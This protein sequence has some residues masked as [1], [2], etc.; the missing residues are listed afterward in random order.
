MGNIKRNIRKLIST[1]VAAAMTLTGLSIT[2]VT[3]FGATKALETTGVYTAPTEAIKGAQNMGTIDN[4]AATTYWFGG[5]AFYGMKRN[6]IEFGEDYDTSDW[7]LADTDA[8]W[9]GSYLYSTWG[10]GYNNKDNDTSDLMT[11]SVNADTDVTAKKEKNFYYQKIL[12]YNEALYQQKV[13]SWLKGKEADA[14][15]EA[16]VTTTGG[17]YRTYEDHVQAAS[18]EGDANKYNYYIGAMDVDTNPLTAGFS[19]VID[20]V[21]KWYESGQKDTTKYLPVNDGYP[22]LTGSA[23]ATD[24]TWINK[25]N[26]VV[27]YENRTGTYINS[28]DYNGINEIDLGVK[29]S[30]IYSLKNAH[31]F[32]PSQTEY[33][34]NEKVYKAIINNI[35]NDATSST[36]DDVDVSSSSGLYYASSSIPAG[37]K[38]YP[39]AAKNGKYTWGNAPRNPKGNLYD[40][41]RTDLWSR[42][43]SG[44]RMND[45][46]FGAWSV[47]LHGYL[48]SGDNLT[49]SRAVAPA[50]NLDTSSVT[51]ARSANAAGTAAKSDLDVYDADNLGENVNFEL[52][53]DNLAI[54]TGFNGQEITNL[55]S[56]ETFSIPYTISKL[57]KTATQSADTK[58]YVSAGIYDTSNKLL[59]YG[60]L[61]EVTGTGAGTAELTI[62]TGLSNDKN[63]KLAVFLEQING[64]YN[65]DTPAGNHITT[66]TTDYASPMNVAAF[67][68]DYSGSENPE[69]NGWESVTEDGITWHYTSDG[70]TADHVWTDADDISGLIKN[71]TLYVPSRINGLKVSGIGGGARNKTFVKAGA[72]GV[73]NAIS[74][75][76]SLEKINDLAFVDFDNAFTASIPWTVK[77]IGKKA[78]ENSGIVN[79]VLDGCTGSIEEGAFRNCK[80]LDEV[81]I[82]KG[83]AAL[84]LKAKAFENSDGF[85]TITIPDNASINA[86]TFSGCGIGTVDY[87]GVELPENSFAGCTSITDVFL[88]ENVATVNYNWNGQADVQST[89][90]RR[91]VV[92][93]GDTEFEFY[94]DSTDKY[95]AFGTKGIVTVFYNQGSTTGTKS[96]T[97]NITKVKTTI[98]EKYKD[99]VEYTAYYKDGGTNLA[100]DVIFVSANSISSSDDD[101]EKNAYA[102]LSEGAVAVQDGILAYAT[103]NV[104]FDDTKGGTKLEKNNYAVIAKY[105]DTLGNE[106]DNDKKYAIRSSEIAGKTDDEIKKATVS[107]NAEDLAKGYIDVTAVVFENKDN[108]SEAKFTSPFRV[109]VD[110]YEGKAYVEDKYDNDFEYI[111]GAIEDLEEEVANLEKAAE[112]VQKDIEALTE[113]NEGLSADLL[114]KTNEAKNL[115]ASIEAKQT[116]LDNLTTELEKFT[117]AEGKPTAYTGIK[118]DGTKVVYIGVEGTPYNETDKKVNINGVAYDVFVTTAD[119]KDSAGTVLAPSGTYFYIGSDGVHK[120]TVSGSLV[121][122]GNLATDENG[123]TVYSTEIEDGEGNGKTVYFT[124]DDGGNATIV[125]EKENGNFTEKADQGDAGAAKEKADNNEYKPVTTEE[126]YDDSLAAAVEAAKEQLASIQAS[127]DES[128]ANLTKAASGL[129]SIITALAT[130]GYNIDPDAPDVY[131]QICNAIYDLIKKLKNDGGNNGGN[132][133]GD[134][135]GDNGGGNGNGNGNGNGGGNNS[136]SEEEGGDPVNPEILGSTVFVLFNPVKEEAVLGQKSKVVNRN[137]K[138][139]ELPEPSCKGSTFKGWYTGTNSGNEI[140]KDS[141]VE[142]QLATVSLYAHWTDTLLVGVDQ[143]T[144]GKITAAKSV[145]PFKTKWTISPEF[146]ISDVT[147]S[148]KKVAKVKK[149]G[150]TV[151]VQAKKAG[152]AD[153]TVTGAGGESQVYKLYVEKPKINKSALKS[154]S[155]SSPSMNLIDYVN[156]VTYLKPTKVSSSSSSVASL[157]ENGLM[158]I[159]GAGKSKITLF[160]GKKKVKGTVKVS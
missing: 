81:T 31:L 6:G 148:D 138:Y 78:F 122:D 46:Y 140:T 96:T 111:A 110:R 147:T 13:K 7:L 99:A 131:D 45:G 98:L 124:L 160:F 145:V 36:T 57:T 35:R 30:N 34:G 85:N 37:S 32:S 66:Y 143:P 65:V 20:Y 106:Y 88:G 39:S 113:E 87:N 105:G 118:D 91:F 94:D 62:P 56:G 74:F 79:L 115:Q 52:E 114:A 1:A 10:N 157:S 83:S 27:T 109:R 11:Y 22:V 107:A 153:I 100:D 135:G 53:T 134:N 72:T 130:G 144:G 125:E 151:N 155:T 93:N 120:V 47:N 19:Y 29:G 128:K 5:N 17:E 158:N 82:N 58:Y 141:T 41:T 16:T 44:L 121:V 77:Y 84:D 137:E 26:G 9:N 86:Y 3:S 51:I 43:F 25:A 76:V 67:K 75:P 18:G 133:G 112:E 116:E 40:R 50:F 28:T 127:L 33:S 90:N 97:G 61:K 108:G 2:P 102:F 21:K 101:T 12:T 123:K 70:A 63:Y 103:G 24:Q 23:G 38:G 152:E 92:K 49:L 117:G 42:S 59:Y 15:G 119:A 136:G 142:T 146:T 132:N 4:T 150:N 104:Y 71:G 73:W 54:D 80:A 89:N 55:T 149:K 139:G 64:S 68:L 95:S 129:T 60:Q 14:I 159:V 48:Y 126:V 8:M 156:G 69:N 154:A